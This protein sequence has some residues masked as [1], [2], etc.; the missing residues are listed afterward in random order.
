MRRYALPLIL[1][2]AG[3][4]LLG[5][6]QLAA[7]QPAGT[8]PAI[9]IHVIHLAHA[10]AEDVR[11]RIVDVAGLKGVEL[12]VDPRTNCVILSGEAEGINA[13][14]ALCE[15][16]DD[17]PQVIETE[18]AIY[19]LRG[20][21]AAAEEFTPQSLQSSDDV[22]M[23]RRIRLQSLEDQATMIQLGE[24]VPVRSGETY[25]PGGGRGQAMYTMQDLGTMV[26]FTARAS[27]EAITMVLAV[28]TSRLVE[29]EGDGDEADYP[30]TTMGHLASTV[31]LE[32]G[33]PTVIGDFTSA[34][35]PSNTRFVVLVTA[36]A[37]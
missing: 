10:S 34:D 28:E 8:G 30:S 31:A 36:S 20:E 12:S 3:F 32:P 16:L 27:N 7:A 22:R 23:I 21:A 4:I 29:A 13:I 17:A 33:R 26:N 9:E 15:V 24:V 35:A 14:V 2:S 19:E 1:C 11:E 25:G 18:I 5:T 6:T 37:K